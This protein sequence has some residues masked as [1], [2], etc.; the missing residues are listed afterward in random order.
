MSIVMSV[1]D[2]IFVLDQGRKISEGT[3]GEVGSDPK[4]IHAY[5]GTAHV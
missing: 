1:A 2:R 3:P 5:L 4:V